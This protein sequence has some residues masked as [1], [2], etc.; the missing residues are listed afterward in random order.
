MTGGSTTLTDVVP[1]TFE[2]TQM[3]SVLWIKG[4]RQK[5]GT[6]LGAAALFSFFAI[7]F[8]VRAASASLDSA[9]AGLGLANLVLVALFGAFAALLFVGSLRW[10]YPAVVLVVSPEGILVRY[11]SNQSLAKSWSDPSFR[12]KIGKMY[13]HTLKSTIPNSIFT[14]APRLFM[15]DD[16]AEAIVSMAR[17]RGLEVSTVRDPN[18]TS[19]DSI[20]IRAAQR[21]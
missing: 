15:T 11:R 6:G 7:V 17:A 14:W 4:I 1:R 16:A 13:S 10:R 2:F 3:A 18:S 9:Y 19:G 12:L 8:A 21:A 20:L 5:W